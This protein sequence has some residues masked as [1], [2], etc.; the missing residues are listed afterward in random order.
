MTEQEKQELLGLLYD[1]KANCRGMTDSERRIREMLP[2]GIYTSALTRE[3][4]IMQIKF[5]S[6]R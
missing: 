3:L 5:D 1:A 4:A 2:V 6:R